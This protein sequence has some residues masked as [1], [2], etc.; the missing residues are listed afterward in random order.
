MRCHYWI[1]SIGS[2]ECFFSQLWIISIIYESMISYYVVLSFICFMIIFLKS[3]Y[4]SIYIIFSL[5]CFFLFYTLSF[6]LLLCILS[7]FS[8][9]CP[10][11]YK[12]SPMESWSLSKQIWSLIKLN[13]FLH[14]TF[15]LW[16]MEYLFFIIVQYY[17]YGGCYS[18]SCHWLIQ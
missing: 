18:F 9:F 5:C 10:F 1:L 13:I 8:F 2:C 14:F 16:H 12:L 15:H 7:I 4:I 6:L 3:Y 11:F 17:S